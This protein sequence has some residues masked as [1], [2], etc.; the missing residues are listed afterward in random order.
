MRPAAGLSELRSLVATRDPDRTA[1]RLHAGR[2]AEGACGQRAQRACAKDACRIQGLAR[3]GLLLLLDQ[4]RAAGEE[5]EE[6]REEL[7]D[8]AAVDDQPLTL[9]AFSSEVDTGSREENASNKNP[10]RFR[11]K[12]TPVRVRKM[13]QTRI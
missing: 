10:E 8:G 11:A 1:F 2:Q 7:S 3:T 5:D 12:W 4:T 13:R 6:W 9:G